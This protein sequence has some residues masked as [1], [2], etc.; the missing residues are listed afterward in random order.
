[1]LCSKGEI[2]GLLVLCIPPLFLAQKA[3]PGETERRVGA[4][5]GI[6]NKREEERQGEAW[7]ER[8]NRRLSGGGSLLRLSVTCSIYHLP[9]D[10]LHSLIQ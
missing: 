4:K 9:Q 8:G 2:Q 6:R 7:Q 3:N 10:N 1:M 5:R